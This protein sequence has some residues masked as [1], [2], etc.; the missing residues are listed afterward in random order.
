ML[1]SRHLVINVP[2]FVLLPM[3]L[4]LVRAVKL[5]RWIRNVTDLPASATVRQK[6]QEGIVLCVR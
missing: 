6:L 1:M 5:V 2:L 3:P 4:Q